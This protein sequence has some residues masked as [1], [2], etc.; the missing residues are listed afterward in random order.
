MVVKPSE[1]PLAWL[2]QIPEV[3]RKKGNQ[4][5]KKRR[6]YKDL[7]TAF[8]IE[9]TRLADI[10][11]SIMYVWQ[12]QFGN[13]YTVVGRTWDEFTQFQKKLHNILDDNFLVVFVHNFL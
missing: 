6:K 10:E 8:D 1:F 7:V 4:R 12:W 5:T 13:A 2:E 9:T 11:N 3:K